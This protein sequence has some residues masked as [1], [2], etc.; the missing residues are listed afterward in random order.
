MMVGPFV[1][2]ILP[3]VKLQCGGKGG[4]REEIGV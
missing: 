1:K 3:T 2:K 4:D